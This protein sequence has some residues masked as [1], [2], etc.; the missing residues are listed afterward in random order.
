MKFTIRQI[1]IRKPEDCTV[2]MYLQS[3]CLP[4]D[5]PMEVDHGHWWIAY[6]EEGKTDWVCG[7]DAFCSMDQRGLYVPHRGVTCLSRSWAT[8]TINTRS[9][10][11]STVA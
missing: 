3:K 5:T 2:I 11:E 9:H 8:E 1:D 7:S 6:T 10:Q 4:G